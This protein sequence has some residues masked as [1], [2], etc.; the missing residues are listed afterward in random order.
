MTL[1]RNLALAIGLVV[2]PAAAMA[3]AAPPVLQGAGPNQT[4]R[5]ERS[6]TAA[7]RAAQHSKTT[8]STT[9]R[10]RIRHASSK[11]HTTAHRTKRVTRAPHRPATPPA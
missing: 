1:I 9:K 6:D 8:A 3:Q 7:T 11:S 10:S 2:L 4:N 5:V